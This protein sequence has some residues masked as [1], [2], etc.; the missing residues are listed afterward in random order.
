MCNLHVCCFSAP[1]QQVIVQDSKIL[2]HMSATG[3]VSRSE[4]QDTTFFFLAFFFSVQVQVL[5]LTSLS[6]LMT[7]AIF[8]LVTYKSNATYKAEKKRFL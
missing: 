2:Q 1:Q 8:V 4:K 3:M 5:T 6:H 7:F